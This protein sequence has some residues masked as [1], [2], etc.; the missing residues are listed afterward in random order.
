MKKTGKRH[1]K[2]EATETI[3]A[4]DVR[5]MLGYEAGKSKKVL[6][7]FLNYNQRIYGKWVIRT[8]TTIFILFTGGR[9]LT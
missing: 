5:K 6:I 8:K 1:E 2:T 4:D 9:N 3:S 7:S